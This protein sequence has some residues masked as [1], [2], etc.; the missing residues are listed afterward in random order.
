M[1][2]VTTDNDLKYTISGNLIK[3][4]STGISLNDGPAA[5]SHWTINNNTLFSNPTS[6]VSLTNG[7]AGSACLILTNNTN[8]DGYTLTNLNMAGNFNVEPFVNN[9]GTIN[10]VGPGDFT[11]VEPGTCSE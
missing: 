6:G 1:M 9:V 7:A 5:T 2:M 4:N 8:T 3:Q 10:E 11:H